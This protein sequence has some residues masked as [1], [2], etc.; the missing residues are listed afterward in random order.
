MP[1]L[2]TLTFPHLQLAQRDAPKLRGYFADAFGQDS[3]LFHNHTEEG[4]F[5]Y[6][7]PLIQYK[8]LGG[9]PSVM[10]V[11][12]GAEDLLAAFMDL[13][14]LELEGVKVPINAKELT[15]DNSPAGVG[16]TLNEYRFVTP[17]FPFT[18]QNYQEFRALPPAE[19]PGRLNELVR[20]HL[21]QALRGVGVEVTPATPLLVSARLRPVRV[22]FKN[23][24]M[25]MYL[26]HFTA[27]VDFPSG[28]GIGKST[29]RG[30]GTVV[31]V[32]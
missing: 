29:A 20:N 17:Y 19:E 7:Y 12:E 18:Q 6:A 8:V 21:I 13:H 5:R 10:G 14:E 26:G 1:K 32:G 4:G 22:N 28:L 9:V 11:N 15:M 23:Q 16:S 27:N 30:F 3:V 31:R 2:L 24:R 25:Q